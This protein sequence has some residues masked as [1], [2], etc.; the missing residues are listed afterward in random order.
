MG[1]PSMSYLAPRPH[2]CL[3]S[4]FGA[5]QP[6]E[7]TDLPVGENTTS[8]EEELSLSPACYCGPDLFPKLFLFLD[9]SAK[10]HL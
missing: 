6:M 7:Q 5:G 8:K 4:P 9:S 1:E 3:H 10:I 2:T